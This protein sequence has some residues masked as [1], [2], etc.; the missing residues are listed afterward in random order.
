MSTVGNVLFL[1]GPEN[2][3][4]LGLEKHC[5]ACSWLAAGSAAY[6]AAD[7]MMKGMQRMGMPVG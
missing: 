3:E 7:A 1:T 5:L 2:V 6:G 4:V